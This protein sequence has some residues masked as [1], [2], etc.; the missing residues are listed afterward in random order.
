MAVNPGKSTAIPVCP[1]M[2]SIIHT[3][4][5]RSMNSILLSLLFILFPCLCVRSYQIIANNN[6]SSP[7]F[8]KNN[9]T[10]SSVILFSG[11]YSD[12]F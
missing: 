3:P 1:K 8:E 7:A 4:F 12:V 10:L 2:M 5:A 11:I 9:V 6:I